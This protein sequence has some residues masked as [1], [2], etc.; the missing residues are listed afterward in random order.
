[1]KNEGKSFGDGVTIERIL[2][3]CEERFRAVVGGEVFW[4]GTL[5]R[6]GSEEAALGRASESLGS[7]TL[8]SDINDVLAWL[9]F[10]N[11]GYV[12]DLFV[13]RF[14]RQ[15]WTMTIARAVIYHDDLAIRDGLTMQAE[16]AF[17]AL[18]WVFDSNGNFEEEW[19]GSKPINDWSAHQR[20]KAIGRLRDAISASEET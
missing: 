11:P 8:L 18:G 9:S 6:Y 2:Y 10:E 15:R 7:Q 1:M 4:E 13:D 12:G 20:L 14:R 17:R 19:F 5:K 16:A 3:E